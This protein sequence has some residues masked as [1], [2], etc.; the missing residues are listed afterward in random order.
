MSPR[1]RDPPWWAIAVGPQEL[2]V[3]RGL[4]AGLRILRGGR[5]RAHWE[6]VHVQGD[7]LSLM[8]PWDGSFDRSGELLQS[9]TNFK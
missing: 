3:R 1:S 9:G 7:K 8:G 4:P 6:G 5:G 2:S